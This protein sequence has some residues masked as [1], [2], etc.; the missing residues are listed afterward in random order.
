M[1][2]EEEEERRGLKITRKETQNVITIWKINNDP[3]PPPP[4]EVRIKS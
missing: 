3:P 4:R 1:E 2:E